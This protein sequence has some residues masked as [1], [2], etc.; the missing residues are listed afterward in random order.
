[1][2][3][4]RTVVSLFI[5]YL[6]IGCSPET[7]FSVSKLYSDNMVIQRDQPIQVW[8]TAKNGATISVRFNS[9]E[10]KTTSNNGNW[11]VELPKMKT[12]GGPYT[13]IITSD[14]KKVEIKNILIGDVWICSGQS[15][16]EYTLINSYDPKSKAVG[17]HDTKIRQFKV[18]RA[19]ADKPEDKLEGGSWAVNHPDNTGDFTAVGYFFA[20]KLRES[21]DVPIGIINT[22]WGGSRIESWMSSESLGNENYET[23]IHKM[24]TESEELFNT[25]LAGFKKF[26]PNITQE[27][28]GTMNEH[29][30]WAEYNLDE[31]DWIDM[32]VP[33]LWELKFE[34]LDGIG[35]YRTQFVLTEEEAQEVIEIGVGQI[36]ESDDT[37][38]NGIRVGGY[39]NAY[40]AER[41][42][43]VS[44]G[45]LKEGLNIIAIR[46]EDNGGGGGI[47]GT[48]SMLYLKTK[49]GTKSLA[50]IWKFKI[51]AYYPRAFNPNN[52]PTLLYN[53]MIFPLQKY[54][55]K[56]VIWYQGE[57]NTY[58]LDE[59]PIL[60]EQLFKKMIRGWRKD[61]NLGDFPFLFVQ[62]ANFLEPQEDPGESNW[63]TL[64][65]S[66]SKALSLPNVGQ[67]VTIDIG[68]A[69]DIHPKNKHDVG[70]RLA[71]AAKKIAYGE[72]LVY[73]GP[74]YKS[75][76]I[77]KDRVII[78]FDN[79]GSGL[80]SKGNTDGWLDEFSIAKEDGQFVWA[81][82]K[83]VGD[84][85]IVWNDDIK[86]PKH[87][88]Y[89]WAD[90]PEKANF[91]NLEGLPASP[92][93]LI[94]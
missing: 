27:D 63:A 26:F 15:N 65:N 91:Y 72:T 55:I 82:A 36:D 79:I 64:R 73:S 4:T 61:W 68:E 6:V 42:Y 86:N 66:Q 94:E 49:T 18:D 93:E 71:R 22:S 29:P 80:L 28:Q 46:V 48:E 20:K 56:G 11:T 60:Y 77:V 52:I 81:K 24:K 32:T 76:K 51:G 37:Y 47:A 5:L 3:T 69:K 70:A 17:A 23:Q 25:Q 10:F 78:S 90:N 67:A 75:H 58:P 45:I 1:M 87:V 83:I 74:T 30:V 34:G 62:L 31:S 84:Q 40:T 44:P 12:G 89:A 59:D 85:V 9:T 50:G 88:R 38:V 16:M 2:K 41:I 35:W 92:F 33:S 53:K 43:Q 54:P 7:S 8:G 57:S 21:F 13:M 39:L 14:S 19:F